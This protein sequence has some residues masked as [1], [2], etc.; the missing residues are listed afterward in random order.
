MPT[1][2]D[3]AAARMDAAVDRLNA[4]AIRIE[5]MAGGRVS[6]ASADPAR[7]AR[8]VMATVMREPVEDIALS[9]RR[10]GTAALGPTKVESD[11]ETVQLSPAIAAGLGYDLADGDH[12]VLLARPGLPRR[13]VN[14]PPHVDER[15]LVTLTVGPLKP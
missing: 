8:D 5:P 10:G 6:A 12:V 13:R 9:G 15:G 4:E 3:R 14:K 11:G 7:P 2:F 1:P